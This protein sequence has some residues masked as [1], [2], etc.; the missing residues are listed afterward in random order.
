MITTLR[1]ML[2]YRAQSHPARVAY[3]FEQQAYSYHE[4]YQNALSCAAYLRSLGL[5]KGDRIGILDLNNPGVIHLVTGAMLAGII[6]VSINWRAMPQELL[7]ILDNAGIKHFFYG[8]AFSKLIGFTPFPADVQKHEMESL[9]PTAAG[10]DVDDVEE[11]AMEQDVC[12]ILY[13][14]G[15]TGN[16][17]G[18]MLTYANL[19]CCFQLCAYDTPSFGPDARN[20]VCGP[21]YSIFGFG[22]FYAGIYAGATNVLVRMFDAAAVCQSIVHQKVTNAVLVPVMFRLILA[23]EG[24]DKMDFSSLRHV[25]YGG[26]PV[27]GDV[28]L[29]ISKLFHC[30]F[31]QVYGLTETAGVATAL[32]FDDH[33]NILASG[34][35]VHNR[36]LMSAGKPSLGI[37]IKIVDDA[38]ATA[39]TNIPGEVFLKGDNITKGYWNMQELTDKT[40]YADGWFSTGDIGYLDE[41]GYL[42]LVDRKNDMIVSKGVNIYPAEIE[43]ILQQHTAF[44]DVAVIGI[45]DEKAGEAICAVVIPAVA[46][47]TLQELQQ[48]CIGKIADHKIPKRLDKVEDLP[49]NATG[50][51]LRRLIREP[52]WKQEERMI[53]G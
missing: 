39:G 16:P 50:K 33:E 26:S 31:T 30:R 1:P 5:R 40:F 44:K 13:T 10:S 17:K 21:M 28:L 4:Y 46:D 22:A 27:S 8:A 29:K 24:T 43:K 2:A 14:S 37:E 11:D 23:I 25:Q 32:R 49:R 38:G 20:L 34:D 36:L 18:V 42:F 6:P 52:Y 41:A 3:V 19:F 51:V 53:K 35:V 12:A 45:P 48:W 7:F 15:T 47:I 9:Q